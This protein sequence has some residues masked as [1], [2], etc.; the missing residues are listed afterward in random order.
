MVFKTTI[1]LIDILLMM[2]KHFLDST[3]CA[4][5]IALLNRMNSAPFRKCFVQEQIDDVAM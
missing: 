4:C 5:F 1:P 2:L 3:C